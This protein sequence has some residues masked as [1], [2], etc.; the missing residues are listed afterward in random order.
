M[1]ARLQQVLKHLYPP[2]WRIVAS[3]RTSCHHPEKRTLPPEM[4]ILTNFAE[5]KG[6]EGL[7]LPDGPD[8][9]LFLAFLSSRDPQTNQPWC[10]DV[11]AAMEPLDN[12]FSA[13][14]APKV[15]YIWVG[16]RPE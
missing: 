8:A 13:E 15:A 10:P 5:P 2:S 6:P 12:A 3:P 9:K 7:T 16:Q 11:R 1:N 14:G 4:P